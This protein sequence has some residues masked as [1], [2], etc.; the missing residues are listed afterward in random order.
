MGQPLTDDYEKFN[1]KYGGI[2]TNSD[3]EWDFEIRDGILEGKFHTATFAEYIGLKGNTLKLI[4]FR[5]GFTAQTIKVIFAIF[6]DGTVDGAWVDVSD[7][8]VGGEISG[9]ETSKS[10]GP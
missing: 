10:T 4:E 6:E 1:G 3:Y 2:A 8:F 7:D 9:G 5:F